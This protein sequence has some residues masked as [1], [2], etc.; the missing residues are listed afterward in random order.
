MTNR[1]I[2]A[3]LQFPSEIAID[4]AINEVE[5]IGAAEELTIVVTLLSRAKNNLSNFL[6]RQARME[7]KNICTHHPNDRDINDDGNPICT[8]CGD[9][10]INGKWR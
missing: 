4:K 7:S 6:D 2:I 3:A 9:H 10:L 5:K 1:R 8:L